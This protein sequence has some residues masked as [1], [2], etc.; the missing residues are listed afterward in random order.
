MKM[1]VAM[2]FQNNSIR[3][4]N[5]SSSIVIPQTEKNKNIDLIIKTS[6]VMRFTL[7]SFSAAPLG[8]E[9][10]A[11]NLWVLSYSAVFIIELL[12][13]YYNKNIIQFVD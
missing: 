11:D 2:S 1:R 12:L 7:Y 6:F 9:Q 4:R 8:G 5:Q 13:H 3:G 10:F